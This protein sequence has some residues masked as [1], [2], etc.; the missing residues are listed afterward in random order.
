MKNRIT[1]R[2][3]FFSEYLKA[4]RNGMVNAGFTNENIEQVTNRLQPIVDDIKRIMKANGMNFV[5]NERM[6]PIPKCVDCKKKVGLNG[7]MR[8]PDKKSTICEKCLVK[9]TGHLYG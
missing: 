9:R 1:N 8:L 3:S 7:A 4:Y 2:D 6:Q 5:K